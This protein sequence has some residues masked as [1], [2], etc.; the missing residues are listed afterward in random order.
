MRPARDQCIGGRMASSSISFVTVIP[1]Q[2]VNGPCPE[3]FG[4]CFFA[5]AMK[6]PVDF[7]VSGD[8][9]DSTILLRNRHGFH[10]RSIVIK[11]N[12]LHGIQFA[13]D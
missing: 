7:T 13:S 2:I 6:L 5:S 1:C 10:Y 12:Q 9:L 4:F 8:C 11:D 3:C